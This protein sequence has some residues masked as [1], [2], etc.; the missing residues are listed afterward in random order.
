MGV[1]PAL[2]DDDMPTRSVLEIV[3]EVADVPIGASCACARTRAPMR[4][5]P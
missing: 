4:V 5:C 3:E 1:D 2:A